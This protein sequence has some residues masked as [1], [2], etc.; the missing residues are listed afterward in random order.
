MLLLLLAGANAGTSVT[1]SGTVKYESVPINT[2]THTL[3]TAGTTAVAA[4]YV[5]VQLINAAGVSVASTKSNASGAYTVTGTVSGSFK[6]RMVSEMTQST[7]PTYDFQVRNSTS[8][9]SGTTYAVDSSSQ[10]VAGAGPYTV[11]VTALDSNRGNGPFAILDVI[12]S[13]VDKIYT[14]DANTTF[15]TLHVKWTST[16]NTGSFFTTASSTCGSGIPNCIFLLGNRSSDSD[17]FDTH[18]IAHE[19]THYLESSLSRSD[20]I[21]GSH[22]SNDL[23]D[24]RVAW[25]EGLGNAMSGIIL[26]D[27]QY[28]D[29]TNAGGFGFS[30]E[31]QVHTLNG[32]YAESSVQAILWDIYDNVADSRNGQTD[33]LNYTFA[34]IW[35]A[36]LAIKNINGITYLHEFIAALKTQNAGD[37]AAIDAILTME[38]VAANAGAEAN[39]T[40]TVSGTYT[41]L[42]VAAH[43]C[44]GSLATY[45]YNP[46]VSV[47][48]TTTGAGAYATTAHLGSQY[49]GAVARAQ[50]KLFGSQ[51]FQVSPSASGTMTVT[52]T[53]SVANQEDPDVYIYLRGSLVKACNTLISETCTATVSAGSV[54]VIDVRTF[55]TG[56]AGG[57]FTGGNNNSYTVKIDLP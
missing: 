15:P 48:G 50:N 44:D 39:V 40:A 7:S 31:N 27:P 51:F 42:G 33:N 12:R 36:E 19:F 47:V 56:M 34:K 49:C 35:N 16:S 21:G 30:V 25:G 17:E 1:V 55:S 18:V 54:Y 53:D 37:T 28:E 32:F 57:T 2:G 9:A 29:T 38:S 8:S 6:I 43:T 4:R 52:A 14:Q 46:I 3:N 45:A 13:G 41:G 22:S 24:P 23:L 11:N 5:T 20:S 10:A 26:D